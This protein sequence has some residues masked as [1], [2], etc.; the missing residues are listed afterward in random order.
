MS[1]ASS[2]PRPVFGPAGFIAPAESDVLAGTFADINAAFGGNLDPG[3][4]T[5]QG[6]LAS[7]FTAVIGDKNDQFL[8]YI[9]GVDPA[10]AA[11]RMQ[12]GI[13]RIYFITRNPAL[14]TIVTATCTGLPGVVIPPGAVALATD[15]N[16]YVCTGGGTIGP[17]GSVSLQFACVV[18][19]PIAC[20]ATSLSSIYRAIPGWDTVTNAADGVLGV[21][22]ETRAAFETRR[23]QSVAKNSVGMLSSILGAVLDVPGVLDAYAISNDTGG[24]A[25]IGG[26]SFGANQLY[27]A[28]IGGDPQT[29]ANAIWSK[30]LPGGPYW[31]G[32]TTVTV[33]DANSGYSLPLPSYSVIFERPAPTDVVFKVF[34]VNSTAVPSNALTL[35]QAAIIAA[36]AGADGGP[37]ARIGS[38]V[39]ASRF[40]GAIAA[41]GG[42][43]QIID[44]HVGTG[45]AASVTGSIA[46]TVL[47]VTAVASGALAIGQLITG[48]G[49]APATYITA[50]GSGTGGTGTYTLGVSQTVASGPLASVAFSNSVAMTIAQAPTTAAADI[51]LTLV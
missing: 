12:D 16:L 48:A 10:F 17:G 43:A 40:Y 18:T 8:A 31:P 32:N 25:T 47:T 19:G 22:V 5:P 28:A 38:T 6:Q 36:F 2:V 21:N 3:L 23:Q 50:L 4:S 20:P 1:G 11:G 30:K 44:I 49:V 27:V 34:L 14:P 24:T 51:N 33:L 42:W 46:T 35:I 41:L 45:V 37:R 9:N 15:G 39:Y 7:S 29:I 13:A 26:L